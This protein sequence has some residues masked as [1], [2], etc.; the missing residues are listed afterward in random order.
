MLI[1]LYLNK[2]KSESTLFGICSPFFLKSL[3]YRCLACYRVDEFCDQ[4]YSASCKRSDGTL[5]LEQ[6]S[7]MIEHSQSHD[8]TQI[9]RKPAHLRAASSDTR[10]MH[11]LSS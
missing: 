10:S 4:K 7:V 2:K 6:R 5:S 3:L 8:P 9:L 1:C 11:L